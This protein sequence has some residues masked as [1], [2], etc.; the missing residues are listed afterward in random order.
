[1]PCEIL[2]VCTVCS[3]QVEYESN[4]RMP[5]FP[6]KRFTSFVH[7]LTPELDYNESYGCESNWSAMHSHTV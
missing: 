1:M 4:S 5:L 6:P 3:L 7:S 2:G